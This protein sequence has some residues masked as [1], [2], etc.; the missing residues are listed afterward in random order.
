MSLLL[1]AVISGVLVALI[2]EISRRNVTLAA[3]LGALPI[4]SVL[5]ILWMYHDT[6]D[7]NQIAGYSMGVF[8]YVLPSLIFFVLLPVLLR[9]AHLPFYV[10]VLISAAATIMA[11]F[12]MKAVLARCGVQL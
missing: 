2:L 6:H 9:S 10:A 11:F 1:K 7:V 4:V 8:W 3:L 5:A 12:I